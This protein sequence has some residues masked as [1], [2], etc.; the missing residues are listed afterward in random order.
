MKNL[1]FKILLFFALITIIYSG[2]ILSGDISVDYANAG[3]MTQLSFSFMLQNSIDSLDY[4]LVSLPFPFHSSLVPAYPATEGLSLPSGLALTYQ[5]MDNSG[6]IL[7]TVATGQILTETIDSSNYF[8][9]FYASDRKTL[10]SIPANQWFYITFQIQDSNALQYQIASS[11]LQIQLSTVSSV[12]SNAMIY[13]DNLAFGYFELASTPPNAITL[14]ASPFNFGNAGSYLL[15][16]NTYSLNLDVS[17]NFSAYQLTQNLV[18][19]FL[20]SQQNTFK[21]SGTCS[22]VTKTNAPII[23]ALSASLYT[24]TIDT[25]NNIVNVVLTPAALAIQTSFRFSANITNP[26]IVVQNIDITV[27]AVN[28]MSGVIIG[29]GTASNALNTNQIYV[30]YQ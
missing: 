22:S 13:D 23:N 9:R 8:I 18:L 20:I 16:E 26:P 3:S 1:P 27:R 15:T 12:W 10:I 11:I 2:R 29:Y 24:C 19:K 6:N 30:T 14:V 25:T 4:I 7:P 28:Q 17:L 21:W 5:Y